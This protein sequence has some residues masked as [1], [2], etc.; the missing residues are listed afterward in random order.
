MDGIKQI[1]GKELARIFRDKKMIFSTFILPV[2]LMVGL[3]TLVG[4]LAQ[5]MMKDLEDHEPVVYMMDAPASFT[6][7]LEMSEITYK[8]K[9]ITDEA[10]LKKAK[11]EIKSGKADLIVEFPVDFEKAIADY[12]VGDSLPQVKTYYNPSEEYSG[13]AYDQISNQALEGYRQAL[14][15][16][17][18]GDVSTLTVFTVNSDNDEAI[19]QDEEKASGK[20]AGMMLPYFIT[21]LLFAGAMSI[22]TDMVAGEKERGTMASLLVSPLKRSSI[23]LGK[24]FALMVISGISALI[25]VVTMVFFMPNFTG[26]AGG[27][28]GSAIKLSLS[29]GQIGMLVALMITLS[30]LYASLIV[31]VSVF[32]KSVKEASSYVMPAYILILVLGMMTMFTTKAPGIES[33]MI[34]VYNNTLAIQGVLSSTITMPQFL[35][36]LGETIVIG[37]VFQFLIVKAFNSEK[38]MSA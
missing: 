22:G 31:F 4:N 38:L 34:P 24:V 37:A 5:G 20:A 26:A 30:F 11:A 28:M 15:A 1:F 27:D 36:T 8:E 25:Y 23:A 17:R 13:V 9:V 19:I 7:F 12:Q 3:M 29:P 33:F 21:L 10:Q 6:S 14:L 2:V 18:V 35:L 32:A 16:N